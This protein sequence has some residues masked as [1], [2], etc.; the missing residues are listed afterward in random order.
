MIKELV[1]YGE[2]EITYKQK[3]LL[4]QKPKLQNLFWE[5]TLRCNAKC[6]HCGSRAGEKNELKDE[7]TTEE[8]KSA[9]Q[10][11]ATKY[12]AKEIL[13]NVTGGEPLL[14]QDLFEVMEFAHKLG[15][16]WGMTTNAMLINDEIIKKMKQTGMSAISISL[17]GLEKSHD[18]F[19]QVKGSY[20]QIV[21]NI[22]KLK[23]A[24]FLNY[25]QITTVINKSNINELEQLYSEIQSLQVDSWRILNIEPIG[26]TFDNRDLLLDSNQYKILLNF[27]KEKRKK[28]KFDVTYGCSHFL[29]MNFE[30]EIRKNM[31]FCIAGFVTGSILYN[32]DI[33][34]CPSVERRK[35]LIQ[36]NIKENDFVEVWEN[37]FKWFRNLEK[38]KCKECEECTDWKYCLG[39]SL[40]TWDFDN[41]KQNL[42]LTK[43]LEGDGV[44]E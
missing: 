14:R 1:K 8:I 41:N 2:A 24:N 42:C 3:Q 23:N 22:K 43:I 27:I 33:Y 36:G 10:S 40:H 29:G 17:D 9:F 19:R 13:I 38:L 35:E 32:G 30:K 26:R 15:Y 28:S 20:R 4:S 21:E 25:L 6:K 12:D 11:I 7:L 44:N 31:F 34:V 16:Y 39:G 18:E 5:T 37:K